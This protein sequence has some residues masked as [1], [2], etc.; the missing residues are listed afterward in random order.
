MSQAA[1][2]I[3]PVQVASSGLQ[4]STPI[5][6]HPVSSGGTASSRDT[7]GMNTAAAQEPGWRGGGAGR[8]GSGY[9][10]LASAA[11]LC[12]Q[13][14]PRHISA[15]SAHPFPMRFGLIWLGRSICHPPWVQVPSGW[16]RDVGQQG[17]SHLV[18]GP[19]GSVGACDEIWL[20]GHPVPIPHIFPV[21]R[22][23]ARR[24][25]PEAGGLPD[26]GGAPQE[27]PQEH[28]KCDILPGSPFGKSVRDPRERFTGS[29]EAVRGWLALH[30]RP[31]SGHLRT[32]LTV[33]MPVI[34][35]LAL[36][37][38]LTWRAGKLAS[39]RTSVL[40]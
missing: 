20:V 37:P 18:P 3:T 22:R 2:G 23:A 16:G 15:F 13:L 11:V 34:L 31:S 4:T 38:F 10:R 19:T 35:Q 9:A 30:D 24:S 26:T 28:R 8:R 36:G 33:P 29:E 14:L 1:S 32:R 40:G 25:E 5:L 27:R 12:W 17:H 7:S 6:E 39:P 21:R